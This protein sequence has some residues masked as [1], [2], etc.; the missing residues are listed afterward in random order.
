VYALRTGVAA[1]AV[2]GRRP[3]PRDLD[4]AAQQEEHLGPDLIG[5]AVATAQHVGAQSL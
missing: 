5:E 3:P 1:A 4:L 2:R